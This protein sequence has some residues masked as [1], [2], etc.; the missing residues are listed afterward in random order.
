MVTEAPES[1]EMSELEPEEDED[2]VMR[3]C[4]PSLPNDQILNDGNAHAIGEPF[5]VLCQT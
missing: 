3:A 4:H 2:T 5:D 1:R